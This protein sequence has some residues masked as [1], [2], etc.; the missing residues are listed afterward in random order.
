MYETISQAVRSHPSKETAMKTWACPKKIEARTE[1][2]LSQPQPLHQYWSIAGL[3]TPGGE[4]EQIL[5][6]GFI[7]PNQFHGVER[8]E[9]IYDQNVARYPELNWHLGDLFQV[10]RGVEGFNPS[11][12][13]ADLL[14]SVDTAADYVARLMYLLTPYDVTLLVNL[15]VQYRAINTPPDYV[16]KTLSQ[17]QQFRYAMNHG[18]F[19]DG[20]CYIYPGTGKTSTVMGTFIFR[21]GANDE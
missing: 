2:I 21:C 19:Y 16:L 20:R 4:V 14:Q 10:M 15:I 13:N 8:V 9:A 3:C 11:F 1:T 17:C 5:D 6:A 12:V 18:W 7:E